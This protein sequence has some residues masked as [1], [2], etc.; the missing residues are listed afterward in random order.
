MSFL[1]LGDGLLGKE[2]VR[3]TNWDFISRKKNKFDFNN[4]DSYKEF[5]LKYDTIINCIAYTNTYSDDKIK[6]YNIN[7]KSVTEL[8]DFLKI[9]NKKLIHISTDY[10]YAHSNNFASENDLPL[11]SKNWYTYYK[12][13]ADEYI[14]L[15]SNDYLIFRC[16]FK[17][18]PFPYSN[19][20]IDQIGNFDYVNIISTLMIKLIQQNAQGL[21][22]LGTDTKSIYD[23]AKSS[24][25]NVLGVLKDN[26]APNNIT[27]NLKK[28]K[29]IL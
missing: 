27:M 10:V 6:M 9:K 1:I 19:A 2:L 26:L 11:I 29:E 13:L 5:L 21:Y 18:Y 25:K 3:Q 28:I 20:W 16:S 15:K 7:Y 4:L 14:M 17:P 23:L 24:N 8:C 12:L 22:N